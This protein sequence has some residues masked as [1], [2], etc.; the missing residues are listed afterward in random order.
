MRPVYRAVKAARRSGRFVR[1]IRGVTPPTVR[2]PMGTQ[3]S[4]T[5]LASE[6]SVLIP[7]FFQ[8]VFRRNKEPFQ[9][10][11]RLRVVWN[12]LSFYSLLYIKSKF[13]VI[14]DFRINGIYINSA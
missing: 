8:R 2:W 11:S 13:S 6:T 1:V 7:E 3:N 12:F 9:L 4:F 10:L 14:G 5:P